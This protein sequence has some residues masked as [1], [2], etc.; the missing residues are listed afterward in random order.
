MLQKEVTTVKIT[1]ETAKLLNQLKIHPRQPYEELILKFVLEH[2]KG[3]EMGSRHEKSLD[4]KSSHVTTIK[5]TK[6]TAEALSKLKIHP[7]QPYEE[8]ILNLISENEEARKT[9]K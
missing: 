9:K 2:K 4:S 7:R 1:K 3:F 8:A 6:R 5:L